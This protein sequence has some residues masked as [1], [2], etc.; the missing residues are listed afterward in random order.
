MSIYLILEIWVPSRLP[1]RTQK[2]WL[3]YLIPFCIRFRNLALKRRLDDISQIDCHDRGIQSD[4]FLPLPFLLSCHSLV[5]PK[6]FQNLP[7]RWSGAFRGA[8]WMF[9]FY[10]RKILVLQQTQRNA[11]SCSRDT[12]FKSMDDDFS[13]FI[14]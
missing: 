2:M 11:F 7:S 14:N 9:L 10:I 12:I 8:F 6:F 5:I 3:L 13:F 4:Q 1:L